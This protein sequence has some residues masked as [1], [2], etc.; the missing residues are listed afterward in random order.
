[1][2]DD[3][4]EVVDLQQNQSLTNLSVS[5]V[6]YAR[7]VWLYNLCVMIQRHKKLRTFHSILGWRPSH[8]GDVTKS[9]LHC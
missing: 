9:H 3:N 4:P 1:M 8:Q 2:K 7:Q 5:E 6:F